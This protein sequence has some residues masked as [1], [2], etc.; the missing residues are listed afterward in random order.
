MTIRESVIV[1]SK[2][3]G[4][5]DMANSKEPLQVRIPVRIKRQ[6]K[7]RAALLG[8]EPNELFVEIWRQYER[9]QGYADGR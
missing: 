7:A 8:I 6:F 5:S 4:G 9:S 2:K 3:I 1:S